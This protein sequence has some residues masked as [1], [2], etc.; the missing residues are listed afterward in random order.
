[1]AADGGI[2]PAA[3]PRR[4][5]R[6]RLAL[7]TGSALLTVLL[8]EVALRIVGFSFPSFY[9]PDPVFGWEL[10]PGAEAW[11]TREGR[12]LVRVNGAGQRDRERTLAKPPGTWRLALLGDSV[13]EAVQVPLEET[14][15]QLLERRLGSCPAL[16]GRAVEVLNFG[17]AGY[18][19]AQEYL[20]LTHRALDYTPDAA[21]LVFFGGN[22]VANNL[23]ALDGNRERPFFLLGADG[24]LTL[25]DSF[26]HGRGFRLRESAG[27]LYGLANSSRLLQ[28]AKAARSA[29]RL[30]AQGGHATNADAIGAEGGLDEQAMRPPG[31][32]TW[33]AGWEVTEALLAAT[34]VAAASGGLPFG[35]TTATIP[36]QVHPDPAVRQRLQ[37]RLGVADLDHADRRVAAVGERAGFPVLRLA[38][39]LRERAERTG[40]ALHGFANT[41]PATGHWNA[42]GHAAAAELLA[43]WVCT[44]LAGRSPGSAAPMAPAAGGSSAAPA[45]AAPSA[46]VTPAA[47]APA[48]SPHR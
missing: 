22:D 40:T 15:G 34:Q 14:F 11:W 47:A 45:A 27:P 39:A 18:G 35:V 30:R 26:R 28:L 44:E 43:P 2:R 17:V 3:R 31:D 5:W 33:V 48:A 37:Q 4:S 13:V 41:P 25:D 46:P 20:T 12:A 16:A 6:A 7:A 42:A 19:T 32:A 36:V 1:M 8:V 24:E 29:Q 10:R 21:L 38:P 23:R 9:Q